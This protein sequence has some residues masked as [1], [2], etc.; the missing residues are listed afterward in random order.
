MKTNEKIVLVG[1]CFDIL[2]VGHIRFLQKA[3]SLG[4]KLIVLLESDKHIKQL[5]GEGRPIN[6]QKDRAEVLA[7]LEDVDTVI[8][9]PPNI[10]N[11]DYDAF[12]KQINPDI[13]A[14]TKGD[15]N[16]KFKE[17]TAVLVGAKVKYVTPMISGYSTSKIILALQDVH[18]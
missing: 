16:I 1:G 5:K 9:L 13:I 10:K 15:P 6:S 17:R 8:L 18:L 11:E 4:D 2:H 14:T 7:S 12:V 3:R